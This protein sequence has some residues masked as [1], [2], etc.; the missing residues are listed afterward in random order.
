MAIQ[1]RAGAHVP[2]FERRAG[3]NVAPRSA[4]PRM[5]AGVPP[6]TIA[7]SE[8][9]TTAARRLQ[10]QVRPRSCERLAFRAA[11]QNDLR[12]VGD[13]DCSL[14]TA[15]SVLRRQLIICR[16]SNASR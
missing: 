4:A 12:Q 16:R 15:G 7:L 5:S 2:E 6:A 14:A 8:E 1:P 9:L 11:S 3:C 10:W 13:A